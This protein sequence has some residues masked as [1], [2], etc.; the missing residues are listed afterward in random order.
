MKSLNI[1]RLNWKYYKVD[2]DKLQFWSDK[3]PYLKIFFES[4]YDEDRHLAYAIVDR[5]VNSTA[6]EDLW[7]QKTADEINA[8]LEDTWVSSEVNGS[9]WSAYFLNLQNIIDS[10]ICTVCH[11]NICNSYRAEKEASGRAITMIELV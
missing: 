9:R 3:I 1:P 4:E 10:K 7:N 8:C 5:L 2:P 11:S 6:E